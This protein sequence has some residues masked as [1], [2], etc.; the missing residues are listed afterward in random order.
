[1]NAEPFVDA[2]AAGKH[3]MLSASQVRKMAED[4]LLRAYNAGCGKRHF[5]R[6]RLSELELPVSCPA[7]PVPQN[8]D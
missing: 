3:L 1:M 6:F 5:W 8:R 7:S 4:G 2:E